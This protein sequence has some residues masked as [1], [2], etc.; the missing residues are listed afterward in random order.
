MAQNYKVFLHPTEHPEG[1]D[2]EGRAAMERV[3][4]HLHASAP[5]PYRP[6]FEPLAPGEPIFSYGTIEDWRRARDSRR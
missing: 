1:L 3:L 2:A 6:F 5:E 4:A